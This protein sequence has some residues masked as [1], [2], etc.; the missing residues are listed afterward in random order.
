MAFREFTVRSGG[1]NLY[2]G[3]LDGSAEASTTPLITYTNGNWSFPTFTPAGGA[4]PVTDG[5]QVGHYVSIYLDGAGA[6]TNYVARI[7]S[8]TSTNFVVSADKSGTAPSGGATGRTAVIGGAWAGPSGASAFPIGFA[9]SGMGD[10]SSGTVAVRVNFKNDQT[11]AITANM[12]ANDA[13]GLFWRG[14]TSTFGDGGRATV[15]GPA[16]G[17]SIVL[18]TVSGTSNHFEDFLF[19]D[20][21]D[22]GTSAAISVTGARSSLRR[23]TVDGCR[24][25][26][27]VATVAT[28]FH[29]CEATDCNQSNTANLGGFDFQSP[30]IVAAR[31]VSHNNT[32]SNTAGFVLNGASAGC[33]LRECIADTN[34]GLGYHWVN[35]LGGFVFLSHCVAYGNTSH[36]ASLIG[37]ATAS[38]LA[39]NCIFENNGGYGAITALASSSGPFWLYNCAFYNNTSG[40]TSGVNASYK[41]GEITLTATA[42]RDAANGNFVPKNKQVLYTGRGNFTQVTGY[43]DSTTSFPHVGAVQ[44][45]G[46]VGVRLIG[47]ADLIGGDTVDLG[48]FN[49]SDTID[50]KFTTRGVS[51]APVTLAGSPAVSVYKGNST[52]QSTAGVTLTVDFDG[53]TGLNHVRITT[54]SD[55][56]FYAAATDFQVVIT[57]GTVESISVA[58]EIVASFSLSNRPLNAAD[59]ADAAIDEATFAADASKYQAKVWLTDDDT[60]TTD[61]YSIVWHKNGQ[62]VTS[63]ITSPT[64]Q[65]IKIADG[66]DLVASTAMTQIAATGLYRYTEATNRIVDGVGYVVKVQATIDSATRTWYQACSRDT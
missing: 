22:S 28:A 1:S 60:G 61:R 45:N 52:T 29:E 23:T 6:P 2:A 62:P 49:V 7:A 58:G 34:G 42:F 41:S 30:G 54:S 19:Q 57:T 13:G 64:I 24:G 11:Y 12:P 17:A 21:G 16:S 46:P 20:N 63:G 50:F 26:G 48:D 38:I 37:G 55:G 10:S 65:V 27:F 66:T 39:E 14:Y 59:I 3:T 40:A 32:G 53:V 15:T 8:V 9:E 35:G 33:A 43:S 4:N 31:C 18:L 44:N 56:T 51:G 5:L 25:D 36:G 47:H